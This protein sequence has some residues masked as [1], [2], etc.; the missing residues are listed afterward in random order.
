MMTT[1]KTKKV[2]AGVG[3]TVLLTLFLVMAILPLYWIFVTSLK[4][5]KELYTFPLHY[6]PRHPTLAGYKSLFSFSNF[7]V[8][9]KNSLLVSLG[10]SFGAM[11]LSVLSGFA[12]SRL[13]AKKGKRVLELI[14][15]FSQ[16]IPTFIIMVP[17]FTIFQKLGLFDKLWALSLVYIATVVAFS[18]IMSRS[19]FDKVP[20]SLEEAAMI[21]GCTTVQSLRH[22]ILPITLPGMAAIFCFAFINIWNELF[23]AVMLL[24]SP[25]KMTVP[26]AL[27]SFISKAGISWDTMSAGIIIALLP[28]M[29]VFGIG[30]KYI[31]AGLTEGSVKE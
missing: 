14:L 22:V 20:V 28:T 12:L 9:F 26:V 13:K 15:Y 3:R 23:L 11:V 16:T 6:L 7:G 30:Q 31:V 18:T 29:I 25:D 5:P 1:R 19:F 21:D 27:N 10:A 24:M 8:Y 2:C 4:D 17:L